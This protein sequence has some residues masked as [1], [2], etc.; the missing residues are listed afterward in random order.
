MHSAD[1]P[2]L[3]VS[4]CLLGEAV[5]Y[6]AGH[7]LEPYLVDTLARHLV[8]RPVC[9]EVGIGLGVPRPPIQLVGDPRA[10][11]VQ[12]VAESALDVTE[13]LEAYATR[14][15]AELK[16]VSGYIFKRGSPSCGLE[17][18]PV[19]GAFLESTGRGAG[20]MR[21]GRGAYAAGLLR[22]LPHLPVIEEQDVH[23]PVARDRFIEQV[24]V[25]WRWQRL[26]AQP[27]L[28]TLRDL[29]ARL[30]FNLLARGRFLARQP[31]RLL[32]DAAA[33]NDAEASAGTGAGSGAE[34]GA[35]LARDYLH[36]LMRVLARPARRSALAGVLQ[37]AVGE[38]R[39]VL[40]RTTRRRLWRL[41]GAYRA[42]RVP[43]SVPVDALRHA[44]VR[45]GGHVLL[46]QCLL[47]PYPEELRL[48]A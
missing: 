43:L 8:L 5:R 26:G 38:A 7:K 13:A 29:H 20:G 22:A 12:G 9:P 4:S 34:A 33:R 10:P 40:G 17:R 36:S 24:F 31:G 46:E 44:L 6:D 23:D 15:A 35:A 37:Q 11:R 27:D 1:R 16:G 41:I 47:A 39:P 45:G 21:A 28:E 19:H 32:L 25:Y 14:M 2:S 18:V 30:R 48:R 3:G 42:G